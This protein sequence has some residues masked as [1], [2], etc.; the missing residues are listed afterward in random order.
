MTSASGNIT[1]LTPNTQYQFYAY[2]TTASGTTNGTTLTFTATSATVT[3]LAA[4]NITHTMATLNKSVTAG[5]ETITAQGFKYKQSSASAWIT[6]ASGSLTGLTAGTQYQF[7]AYATTTIGTINGD[8]LT[9][10]TSGATGIAESSSVQLSIYPNPV[11]N[12]ELR[13]ESG[14]LIEN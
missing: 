4:T 14:E 13:I 8:T 1:G 10:T 5:S 12:G 3:T 7:Y 6:S 11:V 2:A 9:F